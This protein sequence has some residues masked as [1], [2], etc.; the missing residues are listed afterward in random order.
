MPWVSRLH[1]ALGIVV[2]YATH[3]SL[4]R[5]TLLLLFCVCSL[6]KQFL[7]WWWLKIKPWL[8]CCHVTKTTNPK[9]AIDLVC[10][11]WPDVLPTY[12]RIIRRASIMNRLHSTN[13]EA[14]VWII[15]LL[16]SR[17]DNP[18][19]CLLLLLLFTYCHSAKFCKYWITNTPEIQHFL[20]I[21]LRENGRHHGMH[22][23]L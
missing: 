9:K 21:F 8:R 19:H 12:V 6:R 5:E 17:S 16:W 18:R 4:S 1:S 3:Y 7:L 13:L 23:V 15:I 2:Q 22:A 20:I 14:A 10:P 11:Q